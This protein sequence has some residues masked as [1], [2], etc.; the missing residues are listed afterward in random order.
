MD[1]THAISYHTL[2]IKGVVHHMEGKGPQLPRKTL[3]RHFVLIVILIA[4]AL[5]LG[6][7]IIGELIL[8]P[9]SLLIPEDDG[10]IRFLLE[11]L[12]FIGIDIAVIVYCAL[13]DKDVFC[14]FLGARRGGGRGNTAKCLALGL[15]IGFVMNGVCILAAWLHGD[16]DFSVGRFEPVYLI[17]AL[18]CVFVQSCAEELI[19][20][21]YMMGALRD[22]YPVWVV[23]AVN[24]F[25]FGALHLTNPG[26]TV[27]SFLSVVL[28]GVAL[29]LVVYRLESL[30][31]AIAIHTA[32]NFTQNLLFGLPNS[33]NVSERSF[34][35]L[36]GARSSLFYHATFGIEGA[37]TSIIVIV[38]LIVSVMLYARRKQAAGQ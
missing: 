33:G 8:L 25:F 6:G 20:R 30:W 2:C 10:G 12:L 37:I 28:I 21:G 15:L 17:C 35:H 29:S 27:L 1:V 11:Y 31:M 18:L 23:I 36:E 13:F 16:I 14:S 34:L 38:L 4:L 26:I 24:A 9:I 19:T 3:K 32:W 5:T 22:R 7:E